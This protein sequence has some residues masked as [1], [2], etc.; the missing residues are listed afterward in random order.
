VKEI[1]IKLKEFSQDFLSDL[2][3]VK[4]G[5]SLGKGRFWSDDR[6]EL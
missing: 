6:E 2:L 1:L 5:K 4:S 3:A